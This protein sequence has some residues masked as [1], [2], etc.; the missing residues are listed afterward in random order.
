MNVKTLIFVYNFDSSWFS[1]LATFFIRLLRPAKSPCLLTLTTHRLFGLQKKWQ[2]FL[3]FLPYQK[4]FYYRNQFQKKYPS[5]GHLALPV[6]LIKQDKTLKLLVTA[7]EITEAG[8]LPSLKKLIKQGLTKVAN[9]N[10]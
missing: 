1:R 8:N 5:F 3:Q 7:D 6:I 10:L 4:K 2:K 9:R